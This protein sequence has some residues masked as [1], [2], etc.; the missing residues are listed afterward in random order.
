MLRTPCY[1]ERQFN[2]RC[3][4]HSVWGANLLLWVGLL[5]RCE[6][7]VN[8]EVQAGPL[9]RVVGT[10]LS[11]SCNVSG[12]SSESAQ[13]DFEFSLKNP[14]FPDKNIVSSKN[15]DFSYAVYQ[16]RISSKDV[17]LTHV[18]PTS[19]LFEIKSLRKDDEG[20]YVCSVI[21]SEYRYDGT[22]S[23]TTDVKVIDNS[24]SV[25]SRDST[26]SL[27][28][29]EGEALTLTCQA[30]C[31]TIQ[32]THLSVT[33]YLHKD[34]EDNAQ[35]IISLE[36]DFTLSPGLGF[37]QRYKEGLISLDKLGEAT[38]RL[39]M[40]QLEL[41]DNGTIYCQAQ[42]WIQDPDRSWYSI[43][44]KD[45]EKI[46]LNVKAREVSPDMLS[47]AVRI[48]TPQSTMLEGQELLVSCSIDT[49]NLEGRFF[50]VA[51]L[52]GEIELARIGPT[53]ILLVPSEYSGRQNQGELRATRIG[54]RDY[55]LILKPVRTEDQGD[56]V[57]RAWPQERDNDGVFTQGAAQDSNP[58]KIEISV[59]ESELSVQMADTALRVTEGGEFKLAIK[60]G[61]VQGQLSVTWQFKSADTPTALFTDVI[62]LSKDGVMV[63]ASKFTSRKARAMRPATDTFVL[64]LDEVTPSD[65][66]VY[67]CSVSEWKSDGKTHSQSKSADVTVNSVDSLVTVSLKSRDTQVTVGDPVVLMC[68]VKGPHMPL[69]L[70]WSLQRDSTIDNIVMLYFD[71]TISWNG[72]THHYQVRVEKR[73]NVVVHY[74]QI[75]RASQREK[76]IY[77]CSV[78]A[79]LENVHKK[80]SPSNLLNVM[81]RNPASKL[82]LSSSPNM[83]QNT[84]ADIEMKCSVTAVSSASSL[85]AVTWLLQQRAVNKTIMSSDR[86]AL[87]T[88]GPQTELKYRQR[89]STRRAEGPTFEMTIRQARISDKGS[90]VCQVVEWLQDPHGDWYSL[91]AMSTTTALTVTEPTSD[92]VLDNKEQQLNATEGDEV[93]LRCNIISGASGASFFYKATWFYAPQNSSTNGSLVELDHTGLLSFPENQALRGL[94]GRLRL[95]RPTQSSYRLR[96]QGTHEDDSGT[97]WCQVEKYQLDNE[98]HWQQKAS[99][100]SGAMVLTVTVKGEVQAVA[101]CT[102]GIW[103]VVVI[104]LV[105]VAL[106]VITLLVL[107][108]CRSKD[109]RGKKSA[110]SLWTEQPLMSTKPNAEN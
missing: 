50:S 11:I 107:K 106:L 74:L 6:A 3:Y 40:A 45:A 100:S 62:S 91:P 20:K 79:F 103:M 30:S 60:V 76:G 9:Y 44:Q 32:H 70:T 34:G 10:G 1:F 85:F 7:R 90:Y 93:E 36:R 63:K 108:I 39:K 55:Q 86:N 38:Y 66:G 110:S 29:N 49:Q 78:T 23:A 31:N 77:Q 24:L 28:Y 8:T 58:Q 2:M 15:P 48:S 18:N 68:Q 99:E 57:C 14:G 41:S 35:P 5:L 19:V 81:V 69:T 96:I 75:V 53:G 73:D 92:L 83:A 21:N 72:N 97:Y 22:Y 64:E 43:I 51:W 27:R 80:L 54:N 109:S 94:Q 4:S 26:T 12:F 65:S 82:A 87:V 17:S 67:Q 84:N 61:G 95:S 33:W 102:S 47:L 56:Y 16:R 71:G 52:R 104:V 46:T 37:E 105:T 25:S 88:F 89:I 101:E 98:G 59:A 13:Q 42:E